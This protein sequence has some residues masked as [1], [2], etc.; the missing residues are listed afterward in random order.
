MKYMYEIYK[1][2]LHT[3]TEVWEASDEHP[4]TLASAYLWVKDYDW[5]SSLL[6]SDFS[7]I[8]LDYSYKK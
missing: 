8:N 3:Y 1:Y 6:F 7:T 2:I 4:K 5:F